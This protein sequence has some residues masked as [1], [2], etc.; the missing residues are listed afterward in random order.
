LGE[1]RAC[2][3]REAEGGG[4]AV[5]D[6]LFSSKVQS[7]GPGLVGRWDGNARGRRDGRG[8]EAEMVKWWKMVRVGGW[9]R[10]KWCSRRRGRR[11]FMRERAGR[12]QPRR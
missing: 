3:S 5:V 10:E 9:Q 4:G 11:E 12:P 8:G 6:G 2:G 7:R 1:T